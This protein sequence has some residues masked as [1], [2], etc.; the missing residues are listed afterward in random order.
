MLLSCVLLPVGDNRLNTIFFYTFNMKILI[1]LNTNKFQQDH[2]VANGKRQ[3]LSHS[4]QVLTR[5]M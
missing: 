2:L 3:F 1:F 5:Q 4:K